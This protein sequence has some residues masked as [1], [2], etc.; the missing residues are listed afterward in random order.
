MDNLKHQPSTKK[1]EQK[2]KTKTKAKS[3]KPTQDTTPIN[4]PTCQYHVFS[5]TLYYSLFLFVVLW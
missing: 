1:E 5:T 4:N 2:Q 3:K